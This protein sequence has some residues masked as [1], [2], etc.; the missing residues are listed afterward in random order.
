MNAHSLPRP[1]PDR[2]V[3]VL[4]VDDTEDTRQLYA[5]YLERNG[6]AVQVAGNGTEGVLRAIVSR[7]DAIVMDV[8]MPRVD[9]CEATR[10]LKSAAATRVIP[11]I[12]LS[13]PHGV[14]EEAA[15]AAGC[16]AFLSKPCLPG[17]LVAE[18]HRQ[19]DSRR[20]RPRRRGR[21]GRP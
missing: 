15:R 18:L 4:V 16:D 9:G 12:L 21:S 6:F 17:Q 19:V 5:H 2:P 14:I 3:R 1:R 11:V 8:S 20:L 13:T 7:P 10:R